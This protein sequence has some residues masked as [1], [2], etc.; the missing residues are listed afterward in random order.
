MRSLAKL[1]QLLPRSFYHI[2]T[3]IFSQKGGGRLPKYGRKYLMIVSHFRARTLYWAQ[4]VPQAAQ[5]SLHF[6]TKNQQYF[7]SWPVSG[8]TTDRASVRE[9][10]ERERERKIKKP[11]TRLDLS[12]P[13]PLTTLQDRNTISAYTFKSLKAPLALKCVKPL[14]AGPTV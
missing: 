10:K 8:R 6:C 1:E 4:A 12:P 3:L 7:T 2:I 13:R 9:K 14:R 5:V 11:N